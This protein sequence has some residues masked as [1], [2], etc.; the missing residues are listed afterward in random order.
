MRGEILSV[1][2]ELLL[3]QIVNTNARELAVRLAEA[4][5]FVYYQVTVGDNRARLVAAYREALDRSDVVVVTGGLGPTYDDLTKEA[6]AE[7]LGVEMETDGE[8]L[9]RLRGWF[10]RRGLTMTPM[11]EKQA[12]CPRGAQLVENPAGTAPGVLWQQGGKL[13]ALLPGPPHEMRAIFEASVFPR[14][15]A[16]SGEHLQSRVLRV[17]GIGEAS[18]QER[19]EDLMAAE[20]PTVA[21]YAKLAEVELRLTARAASDGEAR[22]LL[23]PAAA[24]VRG[25][26]GWHVYGEGDMRLEDAVCAALLRRGLKLGTAESVTGGLVVSRLIAHPGAS[27]CVEGGIVA[28]TPARKRQIGVEPDAIGDGC[29]A[30]LALALAA[31]ARREFDAD[32]GVGTCGFAGPEGRDVGLVYVAVGGPFGEKVREFHLGSGREEI[33][34]RAAQWALTMLWRELYEEAQHVGG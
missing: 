2:T 14:I 23:E 20:N 9:E 8:A 34:G 11:Q 29:S 17:T 10:Q 25:R 31:A 21:P 24:K 15:R 32:V 12:L 6:L 1:G 16:L 3:G 26:L 7:A 5:V 13:V 22:A 27:A 19:L 30:E 18:V 28:Y 33:R 4:G